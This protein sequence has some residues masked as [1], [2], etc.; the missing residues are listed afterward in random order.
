MAS[1][2]S[3]IGDRGSGVGGSGVG[4]GRVSRPVPTAAELAHKP[5]KVAELIDQAA[6]YYPPQHTGDW[7]N[8]LDYCQIGRSSPATI[9]GLFHARL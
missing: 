1:E 2:G 6:D 7:Q 4:V 9:A 3:G 5:L 8:F